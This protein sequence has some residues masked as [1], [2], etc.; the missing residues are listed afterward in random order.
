MRQLI[1]LVFALFLSISNSIAQGSTVKNELK[2]KDHSDLRI[3]Q[4][5][6][7]SFPDISIVFKAETQAGEPHWNLKQEQLEVKENQKKAEIISLAP[8]SKKRPIHIVL[9]IDKSGSMNEDYSLLFDKNGKPL[10]SID[11]Q[12]WKVIYPKGYIKPIDAAKNAAINFIESFNFE[13]DDIGLI[14]FGSG[15]DLI[16]PNSQNKDSLKATIEAMKLTGMTAL[17]DAIYEGLELLDGSADDGVKVLIALTD[18]ADNQS[19]T[20]WEK[21]LAEAQQRE[22]PL[23]TIGLGDVA[24][25][26]LIKLAKGS[27]GQFYHSKNSNALDSIYASISKKVQA[28]YELIYRSPHLLLADSNRVVEMSFEHNGQMHTAADS[29]ILPE[30]VVAFIEQK[31]KQRSFLL[32]GG[33]AAVVT[34]FSGG[35]LLLYFRR[36]KRL[37]IAKSKQSFSFDKIYPNPAKD[38][39]KLEL[40]GFTKTEHLGVSIYNLQG[41]QVQS[42]LVDPQNPEL[43]VSGIPA[44]QYVLSVEYDGKPYSQQLV[45]QD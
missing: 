44:G 12:T 24:K 4:I 10:Y 22:I 14:G 23:F 8:I 15:V 11:P 9:V 7:D 18:G 20:A 26:T 21:V 3:L 27:G 35:G 17:Y 6:P 30:E 41:Q 33:L 38:L 1:Y 19:S 13:K 36:R 39:I 42:F 43:N 32:Y 28:Y 5:F 29:T 25:D 31:K 37:A 2:S 40:K 16:Y 34:A 45:I